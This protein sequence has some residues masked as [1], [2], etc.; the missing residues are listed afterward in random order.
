MNPSDPNGESRHRLAAAVLGDP[1]LARKVPMLIGDRGP[2]GE[3]G[4]Q[5]ERGYSGPPG[6]D[7]QNGARGD[8][9]PQGEPGPEGQAIQGGP[10]PTGD[11]GD[12][13]PR[14]ETGPQGP[15]GL[16]WRGTWV[17]ARSYAVR[18]A[19]E[20]D[21]SSYVA[22]APSRNERPPG[23]GW[24]VLAA[25]A[26]RAEGG[27]AIPTSGAFGGGVTLQANG[28]D[29][30]GIGK[31]NVKGAGVSVARQGLVGILDITGG[32]TGAVD[33]VNGQTGVVVLTA[34][35][36]GA[37]ASGAAAAAQ[38][39]SDPV[40]AASAAGAAAVAIA[41]ADA[42]S[43]ANAAQAAATAASQPLDSDLTALAGL[44]VAADTLP[45]G[46]GSHAMS[47]TP[48]TAA[49]RALV[50]DADAAA[51]RTTLGLGTAATHPTGDFDAAGAAAA[52]QAASQPLDSDLTAIAALSTT[53]FGRGLLALADAA[54]L[55][56]SGGLVIGTDIEAHDTDLTTIAGLAPSNDDLI[57]RKAGAWTNRTIAQL[58]A[59]LAAAGTTFQPLDSDLTAIAA[60]A[61]AADRV[62]YATGA[63]TWALSPLTAAGRALIDDASAAAQV[64]TLGLDPVVAQHN[65]FMLTRY[66]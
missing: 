30:G 42:T 40:G 7:G 35:D 33:S 43:K 15:V 58:L 25:A 24:N 19:V 60:L 27:T 17:R 6:L 56:T 13:G 16:N 55:R 63:G 29:L 9:G 18:D 20:L 23:K 51:Q 36:V 5:G 53:A 37:D 52:A 34:T 14:G 44:A 47:L 21:G 54:A 2:Q 41:A 66:R 64:T 3:Q 22:V 32:G 48:F 11:K 12:R 4:L 28:A 57:Q 8:R 50:D 59:D 38:A 45:Y 1:T 26:A 65:L 62:P 31:L 49:G 46:S 39:A 61:S 10:G